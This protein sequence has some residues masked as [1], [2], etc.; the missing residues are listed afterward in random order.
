MKKALGLLFFIF[1]VAICGRAQFNQLISIDEGLSSRQVY[2]IEKCT[3]GYMWFLTHNGVDKYDGTTN[4][5][6]DLS[7]NNEEI[8][9]SPDINFL[10]KDSN[11]NIYE[12]GRN[13]YIFKYDYMKDKFIMI[14]DFTNLC[15]QQKIINASSM[16]LDSNNH[17][18]MSL[19]NKQFIFNTITHKITELHTTINEEII[20]F[21]EISKN[22]YCI[23]TAYKVYVIKL[24]N[25]TLKIRYSIK[26][27]ELAGVNY[28]YFHKDTQTLVVSTPFKGIFLYNIKTK[29][30]KNIQYNTI[31]IFINNI[32]SIPGSPNELL[33]ATN[34][35]GIYKLD[36]FKK[37]M[38]PIKYDIDNTYVIKDIYVDEEK[39]TWIAVYPIGI[40]AI[41][42][43]PS[44]FKLHQ[45]SSTNNNTLIDNQV[46]FIYEDSDHDLW[47]LT[48]NGVSCYKRKEDRWINAL[49]H[50]DVGTSATN[51]VFISICEVAPGSFLLSGYMSGAYLIRKKD[52]I[53]HYYKIVGDIKT[54]IPDK[55]IRAIYKDNEGVIWIG[56]YSQLKKYDM[57]T[58]KMV[59]YNINA[60][61][62]YITQR[63]DDN[64]WI[65]TFNGIYS[66]NKK[67]KKFSN[68]RLSSKANYITSIL[69][70]NKD[71]TCIATNGDGLWIYDN[72]R[73]KLKQY[74]RSNSGLNSNNIYTILKNK[75]GDI[76][77]S[78]EKGI[79]KFNISDKLFINW[80]SDQGLSIS[81]FNPSS[82]ILTQDGEYFFGSSK[83]VIS[84]TEEALMPHTFKTKMVF[85]SFSI[86]Y[87][88]VKPG[89]YNSPLK[90]NIDET[91]ELHLNYDQNSFSFKVSSINYDN[92]SNIYYSWKLEGFIDKWTLPSQDK[93]IRY[94]NLSPGE[95]KLRVRAILIDDLH[96]IQERTINITVDSPSW[97]SAWAILLYMTVVLI[98]TYG[99]FRYLWIKKE[100]NTSKE[101]IRFFINTAH[102]IRTPLTLIQAP[103]NEIR[104]SENLSPQG[105]N[106][107]E[108]AIKN[109]QSLT[110]LATNLINF[111]K[112]DLYSDS[113]IVSK[114]NLYEYINNYIEEFIPYALKKNIKIDIL[115]NIDKDTEVYLDKNKIDSIL[116]NLISN[117]IKYTEPNGLITIIITVNY[118]NWTIKISD[119]GIGISARDQKKLF[120]SLFRSYNAT[121]MQIPGSGIGMLLTYRLIKKHQGTI[122]VHSNE[123]VGSTF[124][125]SFPIK[126]KKYHILQTET[127]AKTVPL[128]FFYKDY[129]NGTTHNFD[130]HNA[131]RK[132]ILIIEDNIELKNFIINSLSASFNI[133]GASNGMEALTMIKKKQPDLI[134]SDIMMPVMDGNE[135]CHNIKDNIETSHIPI[136][137]LTALSDKDSIIKGL[138]TKADKYLTKPF[139]L[140]VLKA[141]INNIFAN[142][143][144]IKDS[145]AKGNFSYVNDENSGEGLLNLDQEFLLKVNENIKKNLSKDVNVETMCG[146]LNMSRSSFYNKIKALTDYTP[147]D[148][149]RKIKMAE[150]ARLLKSKRY[151][152]A[153]VADMVGVGDPKYFT[154]IFKKYYKVPPSIYMKQN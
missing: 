145:F 106:N 90:M 58:K 64:V 82:G 112:E 35:A 53:P 40:F 83:G 2:S 57:N 15:K 77:I 21:T 72:K 107:I 84:F 133:T 65:G 31:N 51:H 144:I 109:T 89:E 79:S 87:K 86:K 22:I 110:E 14:C 10:K 138:E 17:I 137:I 54:D 62:S 116:R 60:P 1:F 92:N 16:L 148:Y 129:S 33:I 13:G 29:E 118:P 85:N 141:T 122:N 69:Q 102:D 140:E 11:G 70:Y 56:G 98:I 139:D 25:H 67:S 63:D 38:S 91:K 23:S 136:I 75:N 50:D 143:Q 37:E 59:C 12:L 80:G 127:T 103:L 93:L 46:N 95:Y 100:S 135:L 4:T 108:L 24:D 151:T 149:I 150:A 34:G 78:T 134:I 66:F 81:S 94:T 47:F 74:H 132:D 41:P 128:P 42:N 76:I 104:R 113:L 48:S 119:T 9:T 88:D 120:N 5:H 8:N 124:T 7:V 49:S 97:A 146:Y 39:K 3:K 147:S 18:F 6:Y 101:K 153:E 99:V 26:L 32:R 61:I 123:N 20:A 68:I 71:I 121:N 28:L 115:N 142:R 131:N 125:V 96:T 44:P 52:M 36:I 27:N 55:Y 111:E 73:K 30:N 105:V 19:G 117:A 130:I 126:S 152:V 43:K 45:Y 154:D 114:Y